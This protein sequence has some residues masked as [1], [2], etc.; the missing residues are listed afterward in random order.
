MK[1]KYFIYQVKCQITKQQP[2]DYID[3]LAEKL[4]LHEWKGEKNH[5]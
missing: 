4:F 5:A 1:I 2:I 3:W